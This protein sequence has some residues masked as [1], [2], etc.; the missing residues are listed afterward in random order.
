MTTR[1][2]LRF[3][4]VIAA[5]ACGPLFAQSAVDCPPTAREPSPEQL[6]ALVRDARDHGFLWRI[7]KDDRSSWLYGTV[8]VAKLDWMLPGPKTRAALAATDTIALEIDGLDADMQQRMTQNEPVPGAPPLADALQQRLL[9]LAR[10][11]CLPESMLTALAPE[12]QVAALTTLIGRREGID[13][14]YGIDLLLA[15][16]GRAAKRT[17]VSLESPE[18]QL[19]TLRASSPAAAAELVATALDELESGRALRTLLRV[20]QIWADGDWEAL[21]AYESWCDCVNTATDRAEMARLLD[22]RNPG[23]ADGIAAL[24]ASGKNVFAAVGSLHM[25]GPTGLPALMAQRGYRVERIVN[26][27]K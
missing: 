24:H 25:I 21:A 15:S 27:K 14:A 7:T 22:E 18:L 23:M 12:L 9:R 13:P 10:A 17:V 19:K 26:Q 6:D 16:M 11:E 8:H 2:H 5:F 1:L 3:A 20:A 4:I